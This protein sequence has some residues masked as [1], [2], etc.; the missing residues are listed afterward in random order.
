MA[1]DYPELHRPNLRDWN[2]RAPY[3]KYLEKHKELNRT[4]QRGQLASDGMQRCL[5]RLPIDQPVTEALLNNFD[6]RAGRLALKKYGRQIPTVGAMLADYEN[7]A[8]VNSK[9]TLEDISQTFEH[10]VVC[11]CCNMLLATLENTGS[12]RPDQEALVDPIARLGTTPRAIE[13]PG[14][15]Y[16]GGIQQCLRAF[17]MFYRN[18]ASIPRRKTD[19]RTR[20]PEAAVSDDRQGALRVASFWKSVRDLIAHKDGV[21][22]AQYYDRWV[23]VWELLRSDLYRIPPLE[24][25]K[26]IPYRQALVAASFATH[27]VF[28]K[29]M[30]DV[31]INYSRERRGHVLSPGPFLGPL[32]PKDM[33]PTLPP[34]LVYGDWGYSEG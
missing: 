15:S 17:P 30:R 18:L 20:Q 10:F 21:V 14:G 1:R 4:H 11:W 25:G 29:G 19:P 16:R 12:L 26:P 34:I 5:K 2:V 6:R 31:L 13:L 3:A 8:N 22:D 9:T 24:K 7:D 32:D 23:S 33:P 27:D 28:A